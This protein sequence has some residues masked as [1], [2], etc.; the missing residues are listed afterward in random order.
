M[1]LL[2]KFKNE[3]QEISKEAAAQLNYIE[4]SILVNEDAV[5]CAIY[6]NILVNILINILGS[7]KNSPFGQYRAIHY[8]NRIEFQHQ[9]SP[10]AHTL[11]WLENAPQD[12]LGAGKQDPKALI[13]QLISVSSS[14][15]SG[16]IKLQTHKH[17]FTCY[18][19]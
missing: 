1:Q 6:F 7:K 5:I 11:L 17:T 8:F 13:N 9:G 19:K 3:G 12:P 2:Y 10:H 16:N 15:A 18:K 14:E 4:E